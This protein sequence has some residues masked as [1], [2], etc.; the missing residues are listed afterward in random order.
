MALFYHPPTLVEFFSS[1][2]E[3][4]LIINQEIELFFQCKTETVHMGSKSQ[5][6]PY[7]GDPRLSCFE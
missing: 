6:H 2:L 1:L 4:P 7:Q 3:V 5:R